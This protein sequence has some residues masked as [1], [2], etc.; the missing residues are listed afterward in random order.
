MKKIN[1][2]AFLKPWAMKE[3]VVMTMRDIVIRHLKGENLDALELAARTD[4]KKD[5]P[6]YE[7]IDGTARIPIYGVISK[8]ISLIQ[9][10][11]S[12]G[13]SVLEIRSMLREAASD[14]KVDRIVLDID[15]PGG[16]SDGVAELSDYIFALREKKKIVAFAN[17]SMCSAAYWIGSA[18]EEVYAS[19]GSMVGSIGVYAVIDDYTHANW[20]AGIKT[21]VIKA[22]K[23]KAAGHPDKPFTAEDRAVIQT[24]VNMVYDLFIEAVARNRGMSVDDV[25]K[26]A[27]GDIF[28]GKKAVDT[29]L[30]DGIDDI[31]AIFTSTA[32]DSARTRK[33]AAGA[34]DLSIENNNQPNKQEADMEVKD[35]T[36]EKLKAENKAVADA[37]FAEGKAAGVAEGK[38]AGIAEGK[39]AG[40]EEGKVIGAKEAR[41]LEL[42]RVSAVIAAAPAGMEALALAAVKEGKTVEQAKDAYLQS[43]KAAAPASPGANPDPAA[44]SA[45]S[46]QQLSI[47]EKCKQDWEKDPKLQ[48]EWAS[49]E[50][51]T[52]YT[53]GVAKGRIR[54]VKK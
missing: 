41:D 16:S 26:V 21:E 50:A 9:R 4:G 32:V 54:V 46:G 44:Q 49:L 14:S 6:A 35:L 12:P 45:N 22:G 29:G 53:R 31:D 36:V 25:L 51:Y 7:V 1:E 27:T 18:A 20:E 28:I 10:I 39:T 47:E 38:A 11:S 2:A 34:A 48:Q 40:I 42:A 37:L 15:S 17:G 3:D 19:T 13:T 33:T 43:M 24:E 52:G 5:A 30:V 23:N 8:R